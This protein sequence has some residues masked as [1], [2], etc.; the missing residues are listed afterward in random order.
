ILRGR[1]KDAKK[2]D[3]AATCASL[4]NG[5]GIVEAE[6]REKAT[7]W[8]PD[9]MRFDAIEKPARTALRSSFVDGDDGS[10]PAED[11]EIDDDDV[12]L[13]SDDSI[14]DQDDDQ[15]LSEAA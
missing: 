7:A 6:I 11:E 12:D 4:C 10:D 5:Q 1:Y 14:G 13:L 9:A 3:L 8:L 2:G 15:E